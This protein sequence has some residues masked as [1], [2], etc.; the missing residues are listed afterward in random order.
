MSD[1]QERFTT[2]LHNSA[3]SWRLALDRR[4]KHLGVSQASWLTIAVAARANS[5]L[6]QSELAYRLGVEGATMVAM[7]DR[8]VRAG[9]VIRVPSETDRRVK[10]VDL[11]ENGKRLYESLKAEADMFR[12]ELLAVIAPERLVAATELLEQLQAIL[13]RPP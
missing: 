9:L 5:P 4:L 6:S 7:I 13:D 8:L 1:L 3:R 11:T 2:A 12:R 10:K